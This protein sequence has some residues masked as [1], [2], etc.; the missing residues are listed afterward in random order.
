MNDQRE[1][2]MYMGLGALITV[3]LLLVMGRLRTER[4]EEMSEKE[5]EKF[6]QE[7]GE[8]SDMVGPS[9]EYD[10]EDEM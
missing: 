9:T 5:L 6:L 8:D 2:A 4:Y 1:I 10:S 3:I 7:E